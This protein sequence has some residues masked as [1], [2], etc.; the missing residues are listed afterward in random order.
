[1]KYFETLYKNNPEKIDISL[2]VF[3]KEIAIIKDT[4]DDEILLRNTFAN[5]GTDTIIAIS[6]D[7]YLKDVF[8]EDILFEGEC[9]RKYLYQDIE[10]KQKTFYGNTVAILLPYNA[11][12][13]EVWIDK[14]VLE[15]GR[16]CKLDKNNIVEISMQHEIQESNDFIQ[17]LNDENEQDPVFY[18]VENDTCWQ[19]TCGHPNRIEENICHNCERSKEF[20]QTQYRQETM[21]AQ[22]EQYAEEQRRIFQAEQERR[23]KEKEI[24]EK[25][26][27]KQRIIEE[28][29]RRKAEKLAKEECNKIIKKYTLYGIIVIFIIIAS[30]FVIR[31]RRIDKIENAINNESYDEALQI[32]GESS[33]FWKLYNRYGEK[34]TGNVAELDTKM[35]ETGFALTKEEVYFDQE[36]SRENLS[37]MIYRELDSDSK[38]GLNSYTN[39]T[40][41]LYMI[42]E[43]GEKYELFSE[44]YDHVE[45]NSSYIFPVLWS[46]EWIVIK[47][48]DDEYMESTYY[49][50][51]Y[52]GEVIEKNVTGGYGF[53]NPCYTKMIDGNIVLSNMEDG[54]IVLANGTDIDESEDFYY[55]DTKTGEFIDTT[56]DELNKKYKGNIENSMISSVFFS[57]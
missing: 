24:E 22:Y 38:I 52:D 19:C 6:I 11:R 28:E 23:K 54:N 42:N 21:N 56:Y 51:K 57:L 50:I 26:K 5:I 20:V 40:D 39:V 55:F 2:P 3:I 41:T 4:V 10:F 30:I 27:E 31:M 46:N 44:S 7:I 49:A 45:K 25:E 43:E 12:K 35:I 34:V 53:D 18:Y 36:N 37:Y 48:Y 47:S 17:T 14:I 9:K 29:N 1:M 8:D 32:M 15:D 33:E 13:A 16:V